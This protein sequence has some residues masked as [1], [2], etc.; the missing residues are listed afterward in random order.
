MKQFQESFD[1]PP[2]A[3]LRDCD[4]VYLM[5]SMTSTLTFSRLPQWA[6]YIK[7]HAPD[8]LVYVVGNKS[9]DSFCRVVSTAQG[10]QFASQEGFLYVESTSSQPHI[11]NALIDQSVRT[12]IR[13]RQP[14]GQAPRRFRR[15]IPNSDCCPIL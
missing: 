6:A 1:T 13:R 2:L 3:C 4:I 14:D 11:V 8:A 10:Q 9:D 12:V 5:F 15:L 7:R